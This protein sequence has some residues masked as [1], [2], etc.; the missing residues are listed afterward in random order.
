[1]SAPHSIFSF[2][3]A[4]AL[5]KSI[6]RWLEMKIVKVYSKTPTKTEHQ[7]L[8]S[9]CIIHSKERSCSFNNLCLRHADAAEWHKKPE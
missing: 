5:S 2:P 7:Q 9:V 1:M 6:I 8:V 3:L 4:V